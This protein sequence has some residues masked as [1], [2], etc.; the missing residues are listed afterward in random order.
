MRLAG[1]LRAEAILGRRTGQRRR[2][3]RRS[4]T[5]HSVHRSRFH[6]SLRD[7]QR[8]RIAAVLL[9]EFAQIDEVGRAPLQTLDQLIAARVE[10]HTHAVFA[11]RLRTLWR[12]RSAVRLR[13]RYHF[14]PPMWGRVGGHGDLGQS[15]HKIA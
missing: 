1:G 13:V 9:R 3:F 12:R 8:E 7:R 4:C 14:N 2:Q 11:E 6:F 10:R 15:S 5:L